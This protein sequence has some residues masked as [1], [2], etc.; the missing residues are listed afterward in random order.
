MY[1]QNK[2]AILLDSKTSIKIAVV[3][4]A[5]K[6]PIAETT[7]TLSEPETLLTKE[8]NLLRIPKRTARKANRPRRPV[9][10]KALK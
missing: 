2:I 7:M 10:P 5:A 4:K 6:I 8:I 9:S 1:A 3:K